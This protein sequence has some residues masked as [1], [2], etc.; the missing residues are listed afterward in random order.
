L[1]NMLESIGWGYASTEL[2]RLFGSLGWRGMLGKPSRS[3]F[4]L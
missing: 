1:E 2:L 4:D 3:V